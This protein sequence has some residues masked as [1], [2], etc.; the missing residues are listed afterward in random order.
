MHVARARFILNAMRI[1]VAQQPN[2]AFVLTA[3]R[4]AIARKWCA[5]RCATHISVH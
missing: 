2:H 4:I 5:P 3:M 1:I